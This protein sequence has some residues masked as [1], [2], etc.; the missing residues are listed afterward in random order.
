MKAKS[1]RQNSALIAILKTSAGSICF[2]I[3]GYDATASSNL[4]NTDFIFIFILNK[5]NNN[6]FNFYVSVNELPEH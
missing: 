6:N 1:F 3:L 2:L 4:E 5:D